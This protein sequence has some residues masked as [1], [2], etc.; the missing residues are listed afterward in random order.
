MVD[1]IAVLLLLPGLQELHGKVDARQTPALNV[2]ISWPGCPEAQDESI[3]TLLQLLR[4][5]VLS[6]RHACLED[7][8]LLCHEVKPSLDHF[9]TELHRGDTIHEET[10]RSV[11]PLVDDHVVPGL[12]QLVGSRKP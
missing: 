9:L 3:V 5:D 7:H 6:N 8:A 11:V 10:P 2:E 4:A 12:V 1:V